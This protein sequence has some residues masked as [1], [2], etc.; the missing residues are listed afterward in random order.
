MIDKALKARKLAPF[1]G[2][3]LGR[4]DFF[5]RAL[6]CAIAERLSA[7]SLDKN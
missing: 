6:P 2:L 3:V 7:F 5:H 4:V 1:Q